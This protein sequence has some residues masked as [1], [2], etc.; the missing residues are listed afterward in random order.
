[1][2]KHALEN[3]E[4]TFDVTTPIGALESAAFRA[5]FTSSILTSCFEHSIVEPDRLC[6]PVSA[7]RLDCSVPARRDH[8]EGIPEFRI[9]RKSERL[10]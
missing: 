9:G 8:D 5:V 2:V 3:A 6:R 1:V 10:A 7:C 4:S